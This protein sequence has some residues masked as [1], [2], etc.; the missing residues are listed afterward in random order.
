MKKILCTVLFFYL[1]ST[2]ADIL[3]QTNEN[4]QLSFKSKFD[5]YYGVADLWGV[6]INGINYALA[7]LDGGLSIIN[8]NNSQVLKN[9]HLQ[10]FKQWLI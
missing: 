6:Q 7:T 5:R 1:F 9:F 2:N 8:T 3:C 4:I 10:I